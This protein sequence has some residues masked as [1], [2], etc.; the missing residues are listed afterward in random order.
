MNGRSIR[1][2]LAE[3]LSYLWTKKF[4][5]IISGVIISL[6]VVFLVPELILNLVFVGATS[7]PHAPPEPVKTESLNT[8]S[9]DNLVENLTRDKTGVEEVIALQNF[10]YKKIKRVPDCDKINQL[11][12][13]YYSCRP[14]FN[15][16]SSA[17]KIGKGCCSEN[18]K[19]LAVLTRLGGYP[20]RIVHLRGTHPPGHVA[21][22]V[23]VNGSWSM[24][25]PFYNRNFKL[26]NGKIASAMDISRDP[27]IIDQYITNHI[28]NRTGLS[29][30]ERDE[31]T[32]PKIQYKFFPRSDYYKLFS[33]SRNVKITNSRL[34]W[35]WCPKVTCTEYGCKK[36][37][38]QIL[39]RLYRPKNLLLGF[40]YLISMIFMGVI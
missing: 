6:F 36:V 17:L 40:F 32:P 25:D 3:I 4:F 26:E 15:E 30:R 14:N 9:L 39:Q 11:G 18:A 16:V 19:T 8:T 22:E 28:H 2:R 13:P 27:G 20:S 34:N 37:N 5:K 12:L 23:Y 7:D 35:D 24:F 21:T 10:V 33:V 1:A 38:Y 29:Q 31:I